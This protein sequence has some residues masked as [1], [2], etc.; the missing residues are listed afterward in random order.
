MNDDEQQDSS[1]QLGKGMVIMAWVMALVLLTLFFN[2]WYEQQHNPNRDLKT[3]LRDDGVREVK[4]LR[5][6]YGH[7]VSPGGI[8]GEPVTFLLDTGAT[9]ISIP[10]DVAERIGLPRLRPYNVSTA[11]GTA[12]VYGTRL[13]R[14]E[15]G[16]I[17]LHN[18]RAHINPNMGGDQILLGMNVLKQLELVQRGDTLTLRQNP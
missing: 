8:N 13:E 4:L 3:Q 9:N 14:V 7:Y 2:G 16:K 12:R 17:V 5:N 11:N 1:R 15:L 18:V 6:R 10:A